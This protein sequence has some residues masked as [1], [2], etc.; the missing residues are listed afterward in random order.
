M[1]SIVWRPDDDDPSTILGPWFSDQGKINS[2]HELFAKQNPFLIL[3]YPTFFPR[4][5]LLLLRLSSPF[6]RVL[7]LKNGKKMDGM[8]YLFKLLIH[9]Y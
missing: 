6:Q 5:L 4:N 2:F 9:F 3:S 1:G 7:Q 8:Y